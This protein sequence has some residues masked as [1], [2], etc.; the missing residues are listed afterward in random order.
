MGWHT[1]DAIFFATIG[2][3]FISRSYKKLN[4]TLGILSLLISALCK[5]P[6]YLMPLMGILFIYFE[7]RCIKKLIIGLGSLLAF[8]LLFYFLLKQYSIIPQFISHTTGSTKLIDLI[9]SGILSYL[10]IPF[11]LILFSIVLFLILRKKIRIFHFRFTEKLYPA[12]IIFTLLLFSIVKQDYCYTMA[13]LLFLIAILFFLSHSEYDKKWL[14]LGF[15]L[16]ISWCSSISWGYQTPVLFSMP[17]IFC[18][19]FISKEYLGVTNSNYLGIVILTMGITTYNLAYQNPYCNPPKRELT[20]NIGQLF[21]KLKYIKIGKETYIKYSEFHYLISKYGSNFKTLPGMPLSN[22]VNNSLSPIKI[23]WV[24]NGETKGENV[25][26]VQ[27][28][29]NNGIIVFMEKK[30][31]LIGVEDSDQ[32]FNSSVAYYIK[33]HWKKIDTTTFFDV[34]KHDQK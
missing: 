24:F 20:Y 28:L 14:T 25:N 31:Q 15:L 17:L 19:I 1:I 8:I 4:I 6:F 22:Y 11:S 30:P 21:P 9:D 13:R 12:L 3:F 16:C 18:F 23:D 32:K 2:L 33:E 34:Y 27:E 7:S 26:I 10:E 5:Q 29:E